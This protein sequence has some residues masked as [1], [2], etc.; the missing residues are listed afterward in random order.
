MAVR[1]KFRSAATFDS[2]DLGGRSSISV[3]DLKSEIVKRKHL[4]LCQDFSLVFS[5]SQTGQEYDDENIQ[6]PSGSNVIIKRV[7]AGSLPAVRACNVSARNLVNKETYHVNTMDPPQLRVQTD[8]FDDFGVDLCPLPDVNSPNIAHHI[9]ELKPDNCEI[10]A[11]LV[12]R[13]SESPVLR[14]QKP[15]ASEP[16]QSILR[17]PSAKEGSTLMVKSKEKVDEYS[18]IERAM[19][20]NNQAMQRNRLPIRAKITVFCEKCIRLAL[21]EKR[22]CP[23]CSA[24]KC[25][26]DDLLPNLSLRQAI[27]RFLESQLLIN[28]SEDELHGYAPVTIA[29]RDVELPHSSLATGKGSNKIVTEA[30]YES[31]IRRSSA[32]FPNSVCGSTHPADMNC[33]PK[34]LD[35]VS[36][37]QGENQP[38]NLHHTLDKDSISKKSG[39]FWVRDGGGGKNFT[40]PCRIRKGERT[41]YMCGAPDHLIRDCPFAVSPH[42]A[43]R[44]DSV[45]TAF[46]GV[47]PVYAPPYWHQASL[48]HVR[49]FADMHGSQMM[50][51]YNG[52]MAPLCH[53][54]PFSAPYGP[55][56]YGSLSVPRGYMNMGAMPS[57][58]GVNPERWKGQSELLEFKDWEKRLKYSA[59]NL[60]RGHAS[61][62][63]KVVHSS[64]V[65]RYHDLKSHK[66]RMGDANYSDDNHLQRPE[67]KHKQD[68]HSNDGAYPKVE[69]FEKSSR[70]STGEREQRNSHQER[71]TS[72]IEDMSESSDRHA[73]K[74]HKHHLRH[75]SSRKHGERRGQHDIDSNWGHH[76]SDK[77][78]GDEKK[79][80][81]HDGRRYHAEHRSHSGSGLE[82]SY[83]DDCMRK[84]RD[85]ES[86]EGSRHSR[87]NGE[88]TNIKPH[89][90]RWK[91]AGGST[92]E[93]GEDY[94]SHKRKRVQ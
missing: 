51:S 87:K 43:F 61:D 63:G 56:V 22:K 86:S 35:D 19:P 9:D 4:N 18:P 27:E 78:K 94:C 74:R 52:P 92:K 5:D 12:P 59:E 55:P 85:K 57:P 67:K 1:F 25:R 13:F 82:P 6:I 88:S 8:N 90:D 32:S 42:P 50:M 53:N 30:I 64:E 66:G 7:P 62:H 10:K 24:T 39:E 16:C 47:M 54:G 79:R 11:R 38:L 72:E 37:C 71:S 65:D 69:R 60:G 44:N 81:E 14:C 68:N 3:R 15:E 26:V 75:T 41:C 45:D 33:K 40:T 49:P 91:M 21:A 20:T 34:D 31:Q 76:H 23:I 83:L 17:D 2:V 58:I 36:E 84:R 46:A 80:T 89:H 48:P 70:T 29:Q 28:R 73:E 93:Y 77:G